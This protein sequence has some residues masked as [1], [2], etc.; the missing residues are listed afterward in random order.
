MEEKVVNE[1]IL[2]VR[3]SKATKVVWEGDALSVSSKNA[4]G[5]FDILGMHSNFITLIRNDP[6]VVKTETG[7]EKEYRFNQSV[8]SVSNNKVNIFSNIE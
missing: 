3:I 6:I 5:K 2:H 8:I 4:D 7:E 1:S